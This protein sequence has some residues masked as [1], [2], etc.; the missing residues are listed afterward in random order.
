MK[1]EYG[2]VTLGDDAA[3]DYILD[4]GGSHQRIVQ[5]TPLAGGS[6]PFFAPRGNATNQRSFTIS[7]EHAT[8]DAAALWWNE[9]PDTLADT[10][11]L[12]ITEG[13]SV[14]TMTALLVAVQR[15]ELTGKS[16]TLSYQFIGGPIT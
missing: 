13:A 8:I 5:Q 15:G 4:S 3:G 10:D 7:K 16:T 11:T 12:T 9:H 6:A 14:S 2:S 1:L